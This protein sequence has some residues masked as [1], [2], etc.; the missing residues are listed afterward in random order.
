MEVT[1]DHGNEVNSRDL[2]DQ[3]LDFLEDQTICSL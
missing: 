3:L 2:I 1:I